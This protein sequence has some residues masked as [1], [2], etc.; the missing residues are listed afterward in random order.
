MDLDKLAAEAK[1]GNEK[2]FAILCKALTSHKLNKVIFDPSNLNDKTDIKQIQRIALWK[3]IKSYPIE[4][5][6]FLRWFRMSLKRRMLDLIDRPDRPSLKHCAKYVSIEN[7][8]VHMVSNAEVDPV[9]LAT[10]RRVTRILKS[11]SNRYLYNMYKA[12]IED[13]DISGRDIGKKLQM[14]EANVCIHMGKL[15]Q[16][17]LE[18]HHQVVGEIRAIERE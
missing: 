18:A 2:S 7:E 11:K 17:M 16:I 8:D 3:I 6:D 4:N 13:P 15:K 1:E 12:K 9:I 5:G 14:G 10:R